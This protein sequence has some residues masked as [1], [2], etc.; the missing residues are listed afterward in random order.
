MVPSKISV[1]L[2]GVDF[3]DTGYE[4]SYYERPELYDI[5]PKSG[6][7]DGGTQIYLKGAKFSNVTSD[8]SSV[9][10]RFR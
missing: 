9:R 8:L 10:C 5:N 2:N 3:H 4:F 6:K 7:V 1:S